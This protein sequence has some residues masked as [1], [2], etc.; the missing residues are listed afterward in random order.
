MRVIPTEWNPR[1]EAEIR[2]GD[3]QLLVWQGIPGEK[4]EVRIDHRGAHQTYARWVGSPEPHPARVEPPCEKYAAC[5]GCPILHVAPGAQEAVRRDLV[6][7]ALDLEGLPDVAVGAWHPSPDGVTGFRHV[8][9]VAVGKSDHGHIRLG[10]WGRRNRRVVPIPDCPVAAPVLRKTMAALA[11]HVID[12]ELHPFEPEIGR[13]VLRSAVLRASR[14]T[15]EVLVTLIAGKSIRELGTLAERLAESAPDVVGV[16]LHVNDGPGNAIFQRDGEGVVGVRALIGK[17]TIEE[18]LNDV[19][20]LVGPGD[21]FQTNPGTADVLYRR[22]IERLELTEGTPVVDLYCGVG[23][24][25]LQAAKVTG[26]ALGIEEIEGAV[27]R[28]RDAA[29]R[30]GVSAEFVSGRVQDVLPE[31][32]KRLVAAR[33]V[34]TVNPARRGLEEG[35]AEAILA[36]RPRRIAYVSCNPRALARD[37]AIFRAAGYEVGD[38]ELFDMFPNTPHVEALVV[39]DATDVEEHEVAGRAPRRKALRPAPLAKKGRRG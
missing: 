12:L 29:R 32:G 35:V 9:K 25:A 27:Q 1:G 6:R 19:S 30:N 10:A 7:S 23:G 24:I 4:A 28:A 33:P 36:L 8:I 31:V 16:W 38:V 20:Y 14:T 13:G 34:V 3:Q 39:M 11:H 17:A 22:V 21:F 15:G 26:W 37:A 18:K 5:G 2:D